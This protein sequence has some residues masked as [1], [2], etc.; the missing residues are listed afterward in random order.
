LRGRL[1]V[2][3]LGMAW[4][5]TSFPVIPAMVHKGSGPI[6]AYSESATVLRQAWGEQIAGS[7]SFALLF[8]VLGVPPVVLVVRV[9]LT[10]SRLATGAA[11]IISL[12]YLA[13]LALVQ[14]TLQSIYPVDLSSCPILLCSDRVCS[15][16]VRRAC[17]DGVISP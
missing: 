11:L 15:D 9:A 2:A 1:A 8:S 4:S 6:K 10:G 16:G 17:T 12:V 14:S 13:L 5:V 3:V 7:V